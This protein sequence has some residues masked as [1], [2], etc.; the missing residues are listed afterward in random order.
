M[1]AKRSA[2]VQRHLKPYLGDGLGC[3]VRP[4]LK[5][6]SR[7]A[8]VSDSGRKHDRLELAW[9]TTSAKNRQYPMFIGVIGSIAPSPAHGLP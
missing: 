3:A 4:R 7:E 6:R 5:K 1:D 8:G 9:G 2:A